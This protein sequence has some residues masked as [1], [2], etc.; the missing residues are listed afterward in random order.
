MTQAGKVNP[1]KVTFSG[2]LTFASAEEMKKR[3]VD[4]LGAK[5][6]EID[7]GEVGQVDLTFIQLLSSALHTA[8]GEDRELS[9]VAGAAP[10]AVSDLVEVAGM[11]SPF[12]R[13][14][15]SFWVRLAERPGSESSDE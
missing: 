12:G 3:L 5:Q 14:E 15:D 11:I 8:A 7:F 9:V 13:R 1:R 2:D 6:V 4:S 10:P